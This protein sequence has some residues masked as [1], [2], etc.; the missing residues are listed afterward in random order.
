M[1]LALK[2]AVSVE[3]GAQE[4]ATG[5]SLE[6][7]TAD[8]PTP[9][10]ENS[11]PS[12]A[13]AGA[14]LPPLPQETAVEELCTEPTT[15]VASTSIHETVELAEEAVPMEQT[16]TNFMDPS[17]EII[18]PMSAS[19]WGTD[20]SVLSLD[21]LKPLENSQVPKA[22]ETVSGAELIPGRCISLFPHLFFP[23]HLFLLLPPTCQWD[24]KILTRS[25]RH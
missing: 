12:E 15:E 18:E 9:Y 19:F 25:L 3:C 7:S 10:V 11:V 13:A 2:P 6:K 20:D 14:P 17:Q 8:F 21:D 1:K 22:P 23:Y 16:T 24:F 5:S 4:N